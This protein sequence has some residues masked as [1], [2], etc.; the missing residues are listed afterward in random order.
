MRFS[1]PTHRRCARE[2]VDSKLV[3]TTPLAL[4]GRSAVPKFPC[5]PNGR[6]VT[7]DA[8]TETRTRTDSNSFYEF[9]HIW[10]WVSSEK[11]AGLAPVAMLFTPTSLRRSLLD[12]SSAAGASKTMASFETRRNVQ[13]EIC[14][15]RQ[16]RE[17]HMISS[18]EIISFLTESQAAGQ[19]R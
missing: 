3:A 9:R 8:L 1:N 13:I 4:G 2:S 14:M 11:N 19:F 16:R 17:L 5:P 7:Q 6:H 15:F 12:S 10:T 18:T